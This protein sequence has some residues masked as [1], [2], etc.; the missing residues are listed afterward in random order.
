MFSFSQNILTN[1]FNDLL[2]KIDL[3]I[4]ELNSNQIVNNNLIQ[5]TNQFISTASLLLLK[6]NNNT[7]NIPLNEI[8][9]K[10]TELENRKKEISKIINKLNINL[11][12][13][14]D[15]KKNDEMDTLLEHN[16]QPIDVNY[17]INYNENLLS[18][19]IKNLKDINENLKETAV[20]LKN[21][22]DQLKV[23]SEK[24]DINLENIN[25]G[26]K[27]LN[28]I[29]CNSMCNKIWM[30]VVN[31]LLFIIILLLIVFK[32]ISYLK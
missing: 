22:G 27:I 25:E 31:I 29:N 30:F 5:E 1:D 19:T 2:K 3:N 13:K 20:D 26:T 7:N 28:S 12:N 14:L 8:E 21:Q 9:I 24:I 23:S 11:L 6:M 16:D 17:L 4:K 15:N 18:G 32:V 10:Y